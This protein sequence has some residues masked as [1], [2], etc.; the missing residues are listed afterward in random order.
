MG[1]G[2]WNECGFAVGF[3]WG[4][5]NWRGGVRGRCVSRGLGRGGGVDVGFVWRFVF[6]GR[7]LVAELAEAVEVF[8]GAA[9]EAF[10]LGL[11]AEEGGGDIGLAVEDIEAVGEPEGAVLGARDFDV[12]A[13]LAAFEDVGI[14]GADHGGF[15]AVGEEAGFEGVHAEKGVL[16]EGDAFDG[17]AFLGVDR[18][19]GRD[20][21]GDEGGDVGGVLNADDGEG[22]GIEGVLAGVLGGAGFAFGGLGPGGTAGI[23]AVGSDAFEGSRHTAQGLAWRLRDAMGLGCKRLGMKGRFLKDCCDRKPANL[24][25]RRGGILFQLKF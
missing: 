3:V 6:L 1:L 18:L 12:V 15:Q 21:V 7:E 17:E 5:R 11:E 8:D 14:V 4:L 22:F 2:S 10:G 25:K 20:G 9:V 23:G 19:V 24:E 13:D 16:G